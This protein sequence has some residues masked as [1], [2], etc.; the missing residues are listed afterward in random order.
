MKEYDMIDCP[1]CSERTISVI[2]FPST[3][4]E[5]HSGKNSLG[6][7]VSVHKSKEELIV[8]SGCSKCDK[9]IKEIE[10]GLTK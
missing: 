6:R 4:S 8:Q 1:F 9:S 3:W 5:K 10:N 2:R 7:G